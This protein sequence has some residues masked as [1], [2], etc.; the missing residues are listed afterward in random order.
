MTYLQQELADRVV[1]EPGAGVAPDACVIWLHGLGADGYDFVPIVPEL[2]LPENCVPRFVF[3]HAPIQP[4]TL[5]GGMRMRAWYD[6]LGLSADA[7]QDEAGI[8]DSAQLLERH[9]Q[10]EGEA[11]IPASRIVI[12]GFSQGGAIALHTALRHAEPLAGV[13]ALSTYLPLQAAVGAASS[14]NQRIPILMCH[15]LDDPVIAIGD[16]ERSRDL[17]RSRGY[18]VEWKQYPMQHQVCAEELADI[19]EWLGR[20]LRTGDPAARSASR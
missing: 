11:G 2:R 19:S 1:L 5:N 18:T 3:P 8:R 4:V 10:R 7:A 13:L 16:A 20:I 15:G 12:A 14:A 6:I 17:L 9:I